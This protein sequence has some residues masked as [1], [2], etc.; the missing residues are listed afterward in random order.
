MARIYDD[1]MDHSNEDI[2]VRMTKFKQR[3]G[4]T[5]EMIT[6]H[7]LLCPDEPRN[8]KITSDDLIIHM[9]EDIITIYEE[10]KC[11]NPS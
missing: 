2:T 8:P 1:D 11:E 6:T 7:M 3:Y 5:L 9:L 4:G 10:H